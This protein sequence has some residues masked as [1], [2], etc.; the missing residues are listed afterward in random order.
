MKSRALR[1]PRTWMTLA[2]STHSGR[3]GPG[4]GGLVQPGLLQVQHRDVGGV[5]GPPRGGQGDEGDDLAVLGDHD[6]RAVLAV[7]AL[8]EG[9][10]GADHDTGG[11]EAVGDRGTHM[12]S[13]QRSTS[14]CSAC[15]TSRCR[16]TP[17]SRRSLRLGRAPRF[18]LLRM[19]TSSR[20]WAVSL[21]RSRR[22]V[23]FRDS[24]S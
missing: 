17:T 5:G 10:V 22:V 12:T 18:L 21:L 16:R 14:R 4:A 7:G 8:G 9:E 1:R 2:R 23:I 6:R 24:S 15:W 13:W 20:L 3:A 19:C 11:E